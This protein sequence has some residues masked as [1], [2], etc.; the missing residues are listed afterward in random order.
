MRQIKK[1][2]VVWMAC[3]V[4]AG[5]Y[6]AEQHAP[7]SDLELYLQIYKPHLGEMIEV[8]PM[9]SKDIP[10]F[11]PVT[12]SQLPDFQQD[13]EMRCTK[14][15]KCNSCG[16][17][18]T[19]NFDQFEA[20]K[21]QG[22]RKV[23]VPK[24]NTEFKED[25]EVRTFLHPGKAPLAVTLLGFGQASDDRN[26]RAWQADL[27][28]AGN[29]VL[30]FDSLIRNNMNRAIGHGVAGNILEE[31]RLTARIIHAFLATRDPETGGTFRDRVTSVR[32][33]GA[34]YGGNIALQT[35][36]EPS[37]A[38]WPLDR[39]LII[40]TPVDF[41]N[42]TVLFDKYY[43]EDRSKF[44]KLSLARL[45]G[46]FTPNGDEP[47]EKELSLMRAG[48]GY[49]F[50]GDFV[51]ISKD[52]MERYMPNLK[53]RLRDVA[54]S[55]EFENHRRQQLDLL[56]ANNESYKNTLQEMRQQLGNSEYN[57]LKEDNDARYKNQQEYIKKK[58][59]DLSHWTFKSYF[60]M[61]CQPYWEAKGDY[62]DYGRLK[63][64]MAGAPNFVQV[65]IAEDDPLNDPEDLHE[66]KQALK[67]PQ[68]LLIPHGGHLGYSGT[69]WFQALM[70]KFFAN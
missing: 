26:A 11:K 43:R 19:I 25:I 34:S 50:H 8:P 23:F 35:M 7:E 65:V 2:I 66:L 55:P 14:S 31:G 69:R 52:N 54:G 33:L 28:H 15:G 48:I 6:A 5:C 38:I 58:L 68:L 40:S 60:S 24:A 70:A 39:V 37:S 17:L 27:Y 47:S 10:A 4:A 32:L 53:Q 44:G 1:F 67:E 61:L 45:L 12:M 3:I 51:S 46:G 13:M 42:T 57:A 16:L 63:K 29:H 41:Q 21:L 9:E 59:D 22:E 56:K 64:L 49:S 62:S 36:R 30:S 18:C 20:R